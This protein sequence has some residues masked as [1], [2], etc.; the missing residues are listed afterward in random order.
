MYVGLERRNSERQLIRQ[1]AQIQPD[2]KK[3]ALMRR[4]MSNLGTKSCIQLDLE[5]CGN[6]Q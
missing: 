6:D 2:L 5:F 4:K 1:H 3:D